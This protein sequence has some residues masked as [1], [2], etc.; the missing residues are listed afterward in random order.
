MASVG[1]SCPEKEAG[2]EDRGPLCVRCHAFPG[3]PVLT[4]P[5]LAPAAIM[6]GSHNAGMTAAAT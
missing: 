6:A 5:K 4:E 3:M 1:T 2:V